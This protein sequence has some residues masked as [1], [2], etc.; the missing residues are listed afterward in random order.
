MPLTAEPNAGEPTTPRTPEPFDAPENAAAEHFDELRTL[1]LGEEQGA[2]SSLRVE[3]DDLRATLGDQDALS[4]IIAPSLEG[5]LR[6]AIDQNKE[7]MVEALYPIIG[8]TVVRAVTEAVQDLARTVD[9][10]VRTSFSPA[11]LL[12]RMRAQASGVSSSDLALRDA[13]PFDV[14]EMFL[15][16]RATGLLLRHVSSGGQASPDRDLVSG[17]LTAIRDFASDAFGRGEHGQL[18]TIEY[19]GRRILIEAAQHVYLAV[20][21]DGVEPAGFRAAMRDAVIDVENR[22]RLFLRDYSGDASPFVSVDPLLLG[23]A[24]QSSTAASAGMSSS[25]KRVLAG[26]AALLIVCSLLACLAGW[27]LVQRLDRRSPQIPTFIIIVAPTASPLPTAT[28]TPTTTSTPTPTATATPTATPTATA[29][30]MPT[31]TVTSTPTRGGSVDN[32]RLNVRSGPGLNFP[33]ILTVDPDYPFTILGASGDGDWLNVCCVEDGSAGW[34][35]SLYVLVGEV[36][37]PTATP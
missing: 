6:N 26:A 20:V 14:A 4:A 18:D 19:G 10:R 7:E 21:V 11:V 2:I 33:I 30:A 29:T 32:V 15:I 34:V 23:L 17:M 8:S 25:Q 5:A 3:V 9:S 36:T 13:L 37:G 12:R 22:Y 24:A 16:H 1:L 27:L 31:A 35:S 28:A